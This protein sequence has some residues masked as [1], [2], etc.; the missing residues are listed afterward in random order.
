ML[1]IARAF[2]PLLD[3]VTDRKLKLNVAHVAPLGDE[4][5]F[6]KHLLAVLDRDGKW[7]AGGHVVLEDHLPAQTVLEKHRVGR[8]HLDHREIA[9]A[10]FRTETD[11]EDRHAAP[12][13]QSRDLN[14]RLAFVVLAIAEDDDRAALLPLLPAST[15]FEPGGEIGDRRS[16]F[17][18][19][20]RKRGVLRCRLPDFLRGAAFEDKELHI[21][22]GAEF[23]EQTVRLAFQQK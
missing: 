4:L 10:Q 14:G 19:R 2:E 20:E 18:Q 9:R 22:P 16:R 21:V 8:L 7:L 1:A 12:S 17:R 15:C 3:R 6:P 11:R 13:E 5:L 23:R